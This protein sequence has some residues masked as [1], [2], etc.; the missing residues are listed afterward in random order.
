MVM[1]FIELVC[2]LI[3][4]IE[5]SISRSSVIFETL[6][7]EPL[8]Q[9]LDCLSHSLVIIILRIQ[10]PFENYFVGDFSSISPTF[11]VFHLYA[12]LF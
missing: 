9:I 6:F 4:I 5:N 10:R 2:F 11:W 7:S 3:W 8:V 1:F 12:G